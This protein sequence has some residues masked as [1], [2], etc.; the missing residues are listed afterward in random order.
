MITSLILST[1]HSGKWVL[2]YERWSTYPRYPFS[3]SGK[4]CLL[5][6]LLSQISTL[7]GSSPISGCT[8]CSLP[9]C[10]KYF[11]KSTSSGF[12]LILIVKFSCWISS[13]KKKNVCR[14]GQFYIN[15][16]GEQQVGFDVDLLQNPQQ[17]PQ[18]ACQFSWYPTGNNLHSQLSAH[19]S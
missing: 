11:A 7:V 10:S 3:S 19:G 4:P 15:Y 18:M 13:Q 8:G 14:L 1:Y 16:H 6:H 2:P 17:Y 5:V 9:S 12:S